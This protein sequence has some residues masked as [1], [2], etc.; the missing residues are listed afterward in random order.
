MSYFADY[1]ED[2]HRFASYEQMINDLLHLL[3]DQDMYDIVQELYPNDL[4]V[5]RY[6]REELY[7]RARESPLGIPAKYVEETCIAMGCYW[8]RNYLTASVGLPPNHIEPLMNSLTFSGLDIPDTILPLSSFHNMSCVK[9]IVRVGSI[10]RDPES[11][12]L[13]EAGL[14]HIFRK[15]K[16]L[17]LVDRLD[18]KAIGTI[19]PYPTEALKHIEVM[20]NGEGELRLVCHYAPKL[21]SLIATFEE[22]ISLLTLHK[23][24]PE[25]LRKLHIQTAVYNPSGNE[26]K[27]QSV[28]QLTLESISTSFDYT[29]FENPTKQY[30][31]LALKNSNRIPITTIFGVVT[32]SN[33][34]LQILNL[35]NTNVLRDELLSHLASTCELLRVLQADD[36][37]RSTGSTENPGFSLFGLRNYL[38]SQCSRNLEILTV[39]GHT[40]INN[41]IFEVNFS[42][43]QFLEILDLRDTSC[44]TDYGIANLER[45]KTQLSSPHPILYPKPLSQ[46]LVYISRD[47]S[48]LGGQEANPQDCEAASRTAR[49]EELV[50]V[51]WNNDDPVS[52]NVTV[53]HMKARQCLTNVQLSRLPL[54]HR[55]R[56]QPRQSFSRSLGME[57][58][59]LGSSRMSLRGSPND[60]ASARSHTEDAFPKSEEIH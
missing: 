31:E 35:S 38:G 5:N 53:H 45:Q 58:L 56:S 52:S 16:N 10:A 48:V 6:I 32:R 11:Y 44:T 47:P 25:S 51:I 55:S 18:A 4:A 12:K 49:N 46:L 27:L 14:R 37:S 42:C 59:N 60:G 2:F 9:K 1:T 34:E 13:D 26:I 19:I 21:L 7:A 17:I 28:D 36:T 24:I 15:V 57:G 54:P 40:Q 23:I 8:D 22:T 39:R 30:K 41:E 33:L 20:L 50:K 43:I 29:F 3:S